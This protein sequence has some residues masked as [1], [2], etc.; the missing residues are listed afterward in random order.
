M[1]LE[2]TLDFADDDVTDIQKKMDTIAAMTGK[3]IKMDFDSMA[4]DDIVAHC[5]ETW[6]QIEGNKDEQQNLKATQ[7]NVVGHLTET[8][9]WLFAALQETLN[10][11]CRIDI[12]LCAISHFI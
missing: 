10:E 3:T 7:E 6:D 9:E 2:E 11:I 5:E 12:G 8:N 4:V 1:G